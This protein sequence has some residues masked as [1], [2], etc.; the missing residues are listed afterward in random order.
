MSLFTARNILLQ[1]HLVQVTPLVIPDFIITAYR[2]LQ[3]LPV[4]PRPIIMR[5]SVL[6][7]LPPI[8]HSPASRNT[9]RPLHML[10]YQPGLLFTN[11]DGNR[12]LLPHFL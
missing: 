1:Y 5:H 6:P 10:F 4:S 8:E 7:A 2:V 9:L 3:D 11:I 12:V